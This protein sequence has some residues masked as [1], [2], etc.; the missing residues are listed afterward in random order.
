[1]AASARRTGDG[2]AVASTSPPHVKVTH[3]P[4]LLTTGSFVGIIHSG[5][6]MVKI[7]IFI[8]MIVSQYCTLAVAALEE[9]HNTATHLHTDK[10]LITIERHIFS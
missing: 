5:H 2:V 8:V 7:V 1:M 4:S 6:S 9:E 3:P 10:I